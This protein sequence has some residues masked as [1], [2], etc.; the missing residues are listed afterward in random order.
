MYSMPQ[1]V[2]FILKSSIHCVILFHFMLY[3]TLL[4]KFEVFGSLFSFEEIDKLILNLHEGIKSQ[5]IPEK[6]NKQKQRLLWN[7]QRTLGSQ[8]RLSGGGDLTLS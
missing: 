2:Y 5:N 6:T 4:F 1:I 8:G 7:S 3:F